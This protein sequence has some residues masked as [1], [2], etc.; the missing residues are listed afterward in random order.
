M[1]DFRESNRMVWL[2]SAILPDLFGTAK[3]QHN[4]KKAQKCL[5]EPKRRETMIIFGP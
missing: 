5:N 4:G 1:F 2:I 3:W